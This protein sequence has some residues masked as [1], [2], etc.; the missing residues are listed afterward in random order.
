MELCIKENGIQKAIKEM[1]EESKFGLMDHAM[2]DSG[3]MEWLADM[4]DSSMLKVTFMKVP[5]MKIKLTDLVSTLTTTVLDM[6]D[7]GSTT[8][9]TEMELKNG[10]MV[11]N[12]KANMLKV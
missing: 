7:N 8:N 4:A 6:K 11:H 5:G 2:M 10:L 3:K 12:T 9:N 1:E